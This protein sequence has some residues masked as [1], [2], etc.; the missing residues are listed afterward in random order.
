M[1]RAELGQHRTSGPGQR[2]LRF[3]DRRQ[4]ASQDPIRLEVADGLPDCVS[5]ETLDGSTVFAP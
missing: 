3:V 2:L 4:F 5:V 1:P